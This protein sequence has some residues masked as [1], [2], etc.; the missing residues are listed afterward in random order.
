LIFTQ[1]KVILS[2][3]SNVG[4][5][6][7]VNTLLNAYPGGG[8]ESTIGADVH[9][10]NKFNT[11]FNIWDLAGVERNMGLRQGYLIGVDCA[12]VMFDCNDQA[13]KDSVEQKWI[14]EIKND[15]GDVP[16]V[17]VGTNSNV[18]S[19]NNLS[20]IPINNQYKYNCDEPLKQLLEL[21]NN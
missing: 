20:Y 8:P 16:I 5:S 10:V 19:P 12:I 17:I 1:Y 6:F 4:K 11:T 7:Y 15:I 18:P 9:Q 13:S 21:L 14:P 3:D 2:G